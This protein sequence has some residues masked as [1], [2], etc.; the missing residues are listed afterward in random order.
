MIKSKMDNFFRQIN[1]QPEEEEPI[2]TQK[3][4]DAIINA[5]DNM[6]EGQGDSVKV[7]SAISLVEA[8]FST[9]LQFSYKYRK[10]HQKSNPLEIINLK[11]DHINKLKMA[12]LLSRGNSVAFIRD[13]TIGPKSASRDCF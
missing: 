9:I 12:P 3:V 1:G 5:L 2:K 13:S 6:Q 10:T 4:M 11:Q 8:L 7:P